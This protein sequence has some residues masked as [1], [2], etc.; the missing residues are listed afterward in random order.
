MSE[1]RLTRREALELLGPTARRRGA[2]AGGRSA[3]R[4]PAADVAEGRG[5]SDRAEGLRA[6][7]AGRRRDAVPRALSARGGFRREVRRG[8]RRGSCGE[9]PRRRLPRRE[10]AAPAGAPRQLAPPE[11]THDVGPMTAEAKKAAAEGNIARIVEAAGAP[12]DGAR[13]QLRAPGRDEAPACQSSLAAVFTSCSGG[14]RRR[15]RRCARIRS[16]ARSSSR[17]DDDVVGA[18]G[19]IGSGDEIS[20][21]ERKVFRA[22]GRAHVPP[23]SR[24]PYRHSR[25]LGARAA[26]HLRGCWRRIPVAC[27][28]WPSGISSTR[29][30]PCT[31]TFAGVAPSSASIA[32]AGTT[33]RRRCRW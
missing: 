11:I 31:S 8:H 7:G 3:N 30:S 1:R 10:A 20:K 33:T 5:D 32:R 24:L 17:A 14:I 27:R 28:D 22:V 26:R 9:R 21:D 19:E 15:S 16:S 12:R 13:R 6:G 2:A 29:V 23:T 25:K 4:S 18:F